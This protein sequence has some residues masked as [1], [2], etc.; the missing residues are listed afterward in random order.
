MLNKVEVPLNQAVHPP[1]KMKMLKT[2]IM[3]E[4]VI[5]SGKLRVSNLVMRFISEIVLL[6]D[7]QLGSTQSILVYVSIRLKVSWLW[8]V[9]INN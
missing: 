1:K 2:A 3:Q 4:K 8:S 5:I 7:S 9:K 6:S